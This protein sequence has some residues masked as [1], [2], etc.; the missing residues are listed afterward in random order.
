VSEACTKLIEIV[1]SEA[2][3]TSVLLSDPARRE[4]LLRAVADVEA[5]RNVVVP[6]QSQF[7]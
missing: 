7:Q 4:R 3:E 5:G 6:D 1:V 2:D